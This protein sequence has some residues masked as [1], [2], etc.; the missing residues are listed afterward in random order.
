MAENRRKMK[1]EY[2]DDDSPNWVTY[3]PGTFKERPLSPEKERIVRAL[4]IQELRELLKRHPPRP[5]T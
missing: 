3:P 4:E 5:S 2:E 1:F